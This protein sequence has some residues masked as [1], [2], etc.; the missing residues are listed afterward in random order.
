MTAFLSVPLLQKVAQNVWEYQF[1]V[2]CTC[3]QS[4]GV[5]HPGEGITSPRTLA[6]RPI[7]HVGPVR[8][9]KQDPSSLLE[10]SSTP[11]ASLL[12]STM[13][14]HDGLINGGQLPKLKHLSVR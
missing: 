8:R 11:P 6:Q 12:L 10:S 2:I 1:E 7:L 13:K 14:F 4:A 5:T 9:E 3:P